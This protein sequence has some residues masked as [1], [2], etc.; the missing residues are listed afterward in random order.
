MLNLRFAGYARDCDRKAGFAVQLLKANY[1]TR[2]RVETGFSLH[3]FGLVELGAFFSI[4]PSS[5][6]P[7]A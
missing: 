5:D 1:P 6:K 3:S 4:I 2:R 7:I